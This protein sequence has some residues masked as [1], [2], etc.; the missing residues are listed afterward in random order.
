MYVAFS[1]RIISLLLHYILPFP[2]L[3]LVCLRGISWSDL[4]IFHKSCSIFDDT[5]E[6][7]IWLF[8]MSIIEFDLIFY[9]TRQQ[10]HTKKILYYCPFLFFFS[11]AV[12][13]KINNRKRASSIFMF[14]KQKCFDKIHVISIIF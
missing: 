7:A 6:P 10:K 1:D 11:R 9:F 2:A 13:N 12:H 5:I 4:V 14:K 3:K 8:I